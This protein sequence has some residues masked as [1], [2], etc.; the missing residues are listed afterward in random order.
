MYNFPMYFRAVKEQECDSVAEVGGYKLSDNVNY[1]KEF[2]NID[3]RYIDYTNIKPKQFGTTN[4]LFVSTKK[5]YI[6]TFISNV[7]QGSIHLSCTVETGDAQGWMSYYVIINLVRISKDTMH[8]M[9]TYETDIESIEANAFQSISEDKNYN[10]VMD[11]DHTYFHDGDRIGLQVEIRSH[12]RNIS[13]NSRIRLYHRS[14]KEDTYVTIY[15][16]GCDWR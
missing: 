16:R 13:P 11:L 3:V 1:Y 7:C 2:T 12:Y 4:I 5:A 15:G 6:N 14:E 10:F 8:I 9:G